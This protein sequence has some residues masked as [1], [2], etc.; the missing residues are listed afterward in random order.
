MTETFNM[1]VQA[2]IK[3]SSQPT[4]NDFSMEPDE[5]SLQQLVFEPVKTSRPGVFVGCFQ[6]PKDS[7]TVMEA[8]AAAGVATRLLVDAGIP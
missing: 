2:G 3:P 6:A 1:V 7:Q 5:N 4:S 8:S